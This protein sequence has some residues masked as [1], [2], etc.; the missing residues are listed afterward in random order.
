MG[1]HRKKGR[2]NLLHQLMVS[3]KRESNLT[4][5]KYTPIKRRM[6]VKVRKKIYME[7][8]VKRKKMR[9]MRSLRKANLLRNHQ[10]I[11]LL[12]VRNLRNRYRRKI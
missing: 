6:G 9:M 11:N 3:R 7:R 4:I 12:L 2:P 8:K 5:V 1:Q 10:L